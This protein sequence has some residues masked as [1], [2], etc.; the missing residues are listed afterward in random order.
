MSHLMIPKICYHHTQRI[1]LWESLVCSF[2]SSYLMACWPLYVF[3]CNYSLLW[4][5]PELP[6]LFNCFGCL[7]SKP[8]R[9]ACLLDVIQ[10]AE[11]S[12]REVYLIYFFVRYSGGNADGFK[13]FSL[14]SSNSCLQ[15]FKAIF[16]GLPRTD[17]RGLLLLF[18]SSE[19][20]SRLL[21]DRFI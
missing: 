18:E 13:R 20:S 12:G 9:I 17:S 7:I 4:P 3:S 16:I 11:I 2:W 15:S 14:C 5:Q 10:E 1:R 21:D 6:I 8:H 19:A